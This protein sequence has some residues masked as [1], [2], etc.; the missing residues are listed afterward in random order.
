M[1]TV[2][3][4]VVFLCKENVLLQMVQTHWRLAPHLNIRYHVSVKFD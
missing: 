1:A 2:I 3:A 4:F